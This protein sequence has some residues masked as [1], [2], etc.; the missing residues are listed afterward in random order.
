MDK[1]IT[2][3]FIV[4]PYFPMDPVTAAVLAGAV[5]CA[6]PETAAFMHKVG[7]EATSSI[8]RKGSSIKNLDHNYEIL[9]RELQKLVA[10]ATD[11]DQGRVSKEKIKNTD[12]C[13]KWIT[14]ARQIKTEVEA[15]IH[16]YERIKEKL[17]RRINIVAKEHL[18]EKM[19]NKLDEVEKQLEEGKFLIT[20][21]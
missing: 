16:E 13:Q 21:L 4:E 12:T 6:V 15:L 19:V 14:R 17:R 8:I 5:I 2:S 18:S 11:I 9:D 10:L 3:G 7:K 1:G 20:Y